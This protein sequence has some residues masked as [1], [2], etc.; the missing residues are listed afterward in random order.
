MVRLSARASAALALSLTATAAWIS[1]AALAAGTRQVTARPVAALKGSLSGVAATS[2]SNAWAVGSVSTGALLLHWNGRSWAQIAVPGSYLVAV[3]ASSGSNAWAV[4]GTSREA[5]L[6]HWNGHRWTRTPAP[7]PARGSL[8]GLSVASASSA[9]AVGDYGFPARTLILHWNG[10]SWTRV[11]SPSPRP[12]RRAGDSLGA[13]TAVSARDAWATGTITS[14]TSGP[15]RG[16]LLHWSGRKWTRESAGSLTGSTS[17]LGSLAATS[18][19]NVWTLGC[20][21]EGGPAGGI[22]GHWN[23]RRWTRQATPSTVRRFGTGLAGITASSRRSAWTVGIYCKRGCAS[24]RP[25]YAPLIV[26]W[27][28]SSWKVSASPGSRNSSLTGVAATSADNAWAVGDSPTTGTVIIL[29][30]NGHAWRA[31]AT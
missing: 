6:L 5:L 12:W 22:I 4:G 31:W 8:S 3:A 17:S 24:Q 28:G 26:R 16:L 2:A 27:N 21:C 30:W 14:P 13:V 29:H 23:G 25:F 18:A 19:S 10:R 1:P 7:V 9:W 20:A 15:V 11:P